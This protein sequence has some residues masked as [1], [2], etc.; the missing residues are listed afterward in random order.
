MCGNGAIKI[1]S[2]AACLC[3][4][5]VES[6]FDKAPQ[7]MRVAQRNRASATRDEAYPLQRPEGSDPIP[8]SVSTSE[9]DVDGDK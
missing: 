3:L 8:A 2:R 4:T 6:F 7:A 9:A 1:E 5:L